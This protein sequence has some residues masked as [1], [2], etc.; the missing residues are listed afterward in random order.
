MTSLAKFCICS[1]SS[2][3]CVFNETRTF[4][5]SPV[6]WKIF[7]PM[8]AQYIKCVHA[9]FSM[10]VGRIS[11]PEPV[12]SHWVSSLQ[13]QL[14][15]IFLALLKISY[16]ATTTTWKSRKRTQAPK[17]LLIGR[18]CWGIYIASDTEFGFQTHDEEEYQRNG[19]DPLLTVPLVPL[20]KNVV[21]ICWTIKPTS[22]GNMS[23]KMRNLNCF[24]TSTHWNLHTLKAWI[25]YKV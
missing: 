22:I 24:S 5:C 20:S 2:N 25:Q 17:I 18:F 12:P 7:P 15:I 8:M 21:C 4:S 23:V 19:S 3:M 10:N 11:Q 6:K 13:F 16:S 1:F 14:R 9:L